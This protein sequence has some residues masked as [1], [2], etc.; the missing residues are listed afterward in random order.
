M[1][2]RTRKQSDG[3][4]VANTKSDV[5]MQGNRYKGIDQTSALDTNSGGQIRE[6]AG[7]QPGRRMSR[8]T[9]HACHAVRL[10]EMRYQ[11]NRFGQC[12]GKVEMCRSCSGGKWYFHLRGRGSFVM[13]QRNCGRPLTRAGEELEKA[14]DYLDKD[15]WTRRA[16]SFNTEG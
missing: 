11:P 1:G 15:A 12:H 5:N 7:I 3:A 13:P 9:C 16:F 6:K 2:K 14:R 10:Y 8:A 4:K